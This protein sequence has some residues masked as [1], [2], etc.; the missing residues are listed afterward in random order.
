MH[1]SPK[2]SATGL[3]KVLIVDDDKFMLT[4]MEDMLRGMGVG[5][6]TT[7]CDGDA[8]LKAYDRSIA[9]D[10]VVCDLNMPGTDGFQFM[11]RLGDRGFKGSVVLVSGM[12]GRVLNSAS[13]M[14]RFH[15]L[16]I[17]GALPKPLDESALR[18]LMGQ[19]RVTH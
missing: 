8:A 10:M 2:S 19:S 18:A 6:V 17:L 7:A 14:G 1:P 11:E 12:D 4:V 3:K 13:L 9:P 15:Q 5:D 16:N